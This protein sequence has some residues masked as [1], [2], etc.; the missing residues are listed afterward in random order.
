MN[1]EMKIIL[2]RP[3][4]VCGWTTDELKLGFSHEIG[5]FIHSDWLGKMAKN[6]MISQEEVDEYSTSVG[7]Q[8]ATDIGLRFFR[9]NLY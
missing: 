8:I 1:Y 4:I 2:A 5:H 3:S 9:E 6:K 7:E